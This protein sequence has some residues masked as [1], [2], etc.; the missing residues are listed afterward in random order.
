MSIHNEGMKRNLI[1]GLA[2]ILS[3]LSCSANCVFG[4]DCGDGV[5]GETETIESCPNDCFTPSVSI[6]ELIDWDSLHDF[7]LEELGWIETNR[8]T[9][10]SGVIVIN[11]NWS[12]GP[13]TT[14]NGMGEVQ[15][16][17]MEEA[18]A[19]YLPP[20]ITA[21]RIP[22]I[23]EAAHVEGLV[24]GRSETAEFIAEHLKIAVIRHGE[25]A[26]DWQSLGLIGRD[27]L[28]RKMLKYAQVLNCG[29]LI[30]PIT[31]N[32]GLF[33]GKVNV[34]ALTLLDRLIEEAGSDLGDAAI[35]GGSKEGYATWIVSAVDSR[36]DVAMPGHFQLE[37][38]ITGFGAYEKASGCGEEESSP[39]YRSCITTGAAGLSI[40][41]LTKFK[42]WL[43]D[44]TVGQLYNNLF[45]PSSFID[46]L[47]PKN[48][49]I[50]GDVGVCGLHDGNYFTPGAETPFLENFTQRGW[51]YN[52]RNINDTEADLEKRL[53]VLAWVLTQDSSIADIPK[54][55]SASALID[56][57]S[58]SIFANILPDPIAVMV[59]W[60]YSQDRE[61]NDPDNPKWVSQ[62]MSFVDGGWRSEWIQAP[63]GNLVGWYVE[64]ES[65]I[66]IDN[67]SIIVRDAS[68]I[69]FLYDELPP[70][71]CTP[72]CEC[73]MVPDDDPP[74]MIERGESFGFTATVLNNTELIAKV[75]FGTKVSVPTPYS[76]YPSADFLDGLIGI[77]L[78]PYAAKSRHFSHTVPGDWSLGLH[79]YCGQVGMLSG[80]IYNT[81]EFKFTVTTG[82]QID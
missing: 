40:R 10:S 24:T 1:W 41:E 18:A 71:K 26:R 44:S 82:T 37:D 56:G 28:I 43:L 72:K 78:D 47:Y 64:A 3:L 38:F 14:F 75:Y 60:S 8:E 74:V 80:R 17:N 31:A 73:I 15:T 5:C 34:L 42:D 51:R 23:V 4:K 81:C 68:P 76:T 30:D 11:G 19:I 13:F 53:I 46:L 52:R 66:I 22:G 39:Q 9:L 65:E 67:V 6:R 48:V 55:Q 35:R 33:L 79:T 62:A 25:R 21:T 29:T 50:Y 32:F 2:L 27:V 59:W 61:F 57:S 49:L 20:N 69:R 16:I 12:G 63:A 54:V 7:T 77:F 36:I 58:F 70:L 45:S